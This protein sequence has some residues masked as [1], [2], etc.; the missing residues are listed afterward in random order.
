MSSAAT[1]LFQ[2]WCE[3]AGQPF[4]PTTAEAIALFLEEVP[5]AA[6]TQV[7]RI[8]AIRRAHRDAGAPLALPLREPLK[9]WR[10]GRGWLTLEDTLN[11]VPLAGWLDGF[12]GRR[13]AF[14]AALIGE[15]GF[16]REQ[17]RAV[18]INDVVQDREAAWSIDGRPVS[19]TLDPGPCP[20]CAVTRWLAVLKIWDDWGRSSV[21]GAVTGY[22][23]SQ[24][25]DCL[26]IIG[27]RSIM[28]P[29]LLPA[30][31][32]HGWLADWEPMSTRSISAVLAY[33]QDRA[34]FP[35]DPLPPL[36]EPEGERPD[37][38]RASMQGLEDLLDELDDKVSA[39]LGRYERIMAESLEMI[40]GTPG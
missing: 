17:A 32:R 34:R 29:T 36:E 18:K 37:F 8:Q 2:D 11:R 40:G 20:A 13:D 31:D 24:E 26:T 28:V 22:K 12:V 5:A 4:L 27:H 10:T 6:S 30:I 9:P 7:K 3:A 23:R 33:R 25:H 39:A 19:R 35:T 21:R 16:S 1:S 38:Q 15:C 14:L